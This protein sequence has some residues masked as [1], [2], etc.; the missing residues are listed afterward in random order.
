MAIN[1][2]GDALAEG[3]SVY[4]TDEDPDGRAAQQ[5]VRLDVPADVAQHGV[6][7]RGQAGEVGHHA[8][9]HVPDG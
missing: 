4:A 1:T 8:T 3:N 2:V 5:P 9:G 7:S 6:P